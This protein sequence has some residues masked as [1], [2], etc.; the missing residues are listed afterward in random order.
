MIKLRTKRNVVIAGG[1]GL[2]RVSSIIAGTIWLVHP[3]GLAGSHQNMVNVQ[4]LGIQI[5]VPD[6]VKDIRYTVTTFP[7][8]D[9]RQETIAG[10]S[11]NA[12]TARD[13]GCSPDNM[14]LG[15]LGRVLGQYPSNDPTAAFDYG[16]LVKQFPSFFIA[17]GS[18]QGACSSNSTTQG[19]ASQSRT[20]FVG[21]LA[22]IQPLN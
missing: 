13:P 22:S 1:L 7:L 14:P 5:M 18:P 2:L 8:K 17:V 21:A 19:L 20:A 6:S 10:F 16:Q 11:T 15:S 9:G 4:E 12:L 3:W